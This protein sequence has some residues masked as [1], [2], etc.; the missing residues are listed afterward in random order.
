MEGSFLRDDFELNQY[1]LAKG[2]RVFIGA[3]E[4]AM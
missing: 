1:R 4:V 2:F 3:V